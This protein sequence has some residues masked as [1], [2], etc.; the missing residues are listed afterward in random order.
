MSARRRSLALYRIVIWCVQLLAMF[1]VLEYVRFLYG[2]VAGAHSLGALFRAQGGLAGLLTGKPFV[3]L[4]SLLVACV[5]VSIA[6]GTL[7]YREWARR[8]MRVLAVL[9]ALW[10]LATAWEWY[11]ALHPLQGMITR[12]HDNAVA[13]LHLTRMLHQVEAV[14]VLKLVSVPVLGWLCWRLGRPAV[15]EQFGAAPGAQRR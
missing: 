8:A 5:T 3:A 15:R 6:A 13:M 9:L 14:L 7:L 12:Y 4:L 11:A 10:S 1:A 2:A